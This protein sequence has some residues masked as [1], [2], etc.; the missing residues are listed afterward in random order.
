MAQD[1]VVEHGALCQSPAYADSLT[2]QY[3]IREK[4]P[5]KMG[6]ATENGSRVQAAAQRKSALALMKPPRNT[7]T[8]LPGLPGLSTANEKM[9]SSKLG[10]DLEIASPR[11]MQMK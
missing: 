4:S 5:A 11:E 2:L 9:E 8:T 7:A 6:E 1:E 10:F 3:P